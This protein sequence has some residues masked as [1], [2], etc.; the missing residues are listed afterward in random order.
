M[1]LSPDAAGK[2]EMEMYEWT[3]VAAEAAIEEGGTLR[4]E[5]DQRSV[6][7][8]RINNALFAS[9]D[10]CTH[11]YASLSD[12]TISGEYIECPMHGGMFHVPSGRAVKLPCVKDL[13]VYRVRVVCG[14]VFVET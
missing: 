10:I 9:D 8:Y 3:E 4:V 11:G 1:N 12:G 2:N 13:P 7:L 5:V 6:C 14:K